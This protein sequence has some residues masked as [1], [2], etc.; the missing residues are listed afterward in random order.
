MKQ[1]RLNSLALLS[2]END[3]T[4][5]VDIDSVIKDFANRKSRKVNII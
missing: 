5:S 3:V 1:E 2:V 4:K